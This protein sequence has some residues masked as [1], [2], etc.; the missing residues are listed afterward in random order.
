[1]APP[2][3]MLG[4]QLAATTKARDSSSLR[5]KTVGICVAFF[6]VGIVVV[7]VMARKSSMDNRFVDSVD[8]AQNWSRNS[9]NAQRNL[10]R[11][12]MTPTEDADIRGDSGRKYTPDTASP[13]APF[14][15][16]RR[17]RCELAKWFGGGGGGHRHKRPLQDYSELEDPL[18]SRSK[19]AASMTAGMVLLDVRGQWG[20]MLGQYVFARLVADKLNFG[21]TVN[22]KMLYENW[23]KGHI[24]LN[25]NN[26]GFNATLN[27]PLQHIDYGKH[28]TNFT[29]IVA[30]KTPR[31]L[32]MWG[33]PF[34]DYSPY[35]ANARQIR[36]EYLKIDLACLHWNITAWPGERDVVV[37]IRMYQPCGEH[38]HTFSPRGSFVD[39]PLK[40]YVKILDHIEESMQEDGGM[41]TVWL[42]SRCG[43]DSAVARALIKQYNARVIPPPQPKMKSAEMTDWLWLAAARRVIMA[44]STFSWWAAFLGNAV[45]VHY[46]LVG[47]WWGRRPRHRL[48]PTEKRYVFHDLYN[49]RYFQSYEDL[50]PQIA[51]LQPMRTG[52]EK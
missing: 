30:D 49:D 23:Q 47:E 34:A 15:R 38:T 9:I 44:Q 43:S 3:K 25:I 32:H 33:Y 24:F 4:R 46:P 22:S 12:P 28:A 8:A 13:Q 1:M 16:H 48:Y 42:A 26:I 52:R 37:H 35:G 2:S 14:P 41:G 18:L 19:G 45:E 39:P 31:T 29:A 27:K 36:E 11:G 51:E 40:Y 5:S 21:L 7:Y 10:K 6:L 20:N 17:E 50:V